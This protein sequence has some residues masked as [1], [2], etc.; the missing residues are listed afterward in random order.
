MYSRFQKVSISIQMLFIFL[1]E[2]HYK[3]KKE[4]VYRKTFLN[5]RSIKKENKKIGELLSILVPDFVKES[6]IRGVQTLSEDQGDVAIL[7]CDICNF[8]LIIKHESCGVI[9][10]LDN[11]YRIFDGFCLENNVQKIEVNFN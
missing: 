5:E 10:L 7:F 8:D 6:L 1:H 2:M 3:Y 4:L 9:K 11:L